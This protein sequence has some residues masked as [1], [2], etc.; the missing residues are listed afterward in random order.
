MNA[1]ATRFGYPESLLFE[2]D[3]WVVLQRPAQVTLGSL[4]LCCKEEATAFGD[5]SAAASGDLGKVTKRLEAGLR[6]AF[7]FDKINY[8]MLMM[9]D[10][11]VHF[12]VI[13]RYEKARELAG[14]SFADAAWPGPPDVTVALALGDAQA[15][16]LRALLSQH[17]G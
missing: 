11:H 5:I 13:P 7:D 3:H 15:E 8:L 9:V 4:I 14:A 12:H 10:P 16:A 1:T 17:L 6:A 2:S